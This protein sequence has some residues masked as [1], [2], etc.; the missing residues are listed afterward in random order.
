MGY[1]RTD[2]MNKLFETILKLDSIEECYSFFE[3]ICTIKEMQDMAQRL[4]VAVLLDKGENYQK[5]SQDV[6]VSTATISRVS[7]CLR[8]G[9]GGYRLALDKMKQEEGQA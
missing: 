2:E 8:Y 7:K 5:I 3:D 6:S 9:S 4:A 1:T